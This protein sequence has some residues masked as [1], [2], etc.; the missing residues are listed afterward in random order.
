[1][2]KRITLAASAALVTALLT[3]G[4]NAGNPCAS[5]APP[6]PAELAAAQQGADIERAVA[7]GE[8]DL[9]NGVWIYD[10]DSKKSK[11]K[12]PVKKA[13]R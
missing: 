12:N 3:G 9:E 8:C 13:A 5:M 1:M 4:C 2:M 10:K 6:T 7:G 11:T